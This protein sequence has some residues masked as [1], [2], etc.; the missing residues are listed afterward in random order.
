MGGVEKTGEELVINR[1]AMADAGNNY[2]FFWK[3]DLIENTVWP[4]TEGIVI[5]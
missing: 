5:F 4:S 3:I 1:L 2:L